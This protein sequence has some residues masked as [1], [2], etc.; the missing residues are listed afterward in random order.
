MF[1]CSMLHCSGYAHGAVQP[2]RCVGLVSCQ[3]LSALHHCS[4]GSL[5]FVVHMFVGAV[6]SR[7]PIQISQK[8]KAKKLKT[9]PFAFQLTFCSEL[10]QDSRSGCSLL[11]P[12]LSPSR[13]L[14][15][16]EGSHLHPHRAGRHPGARCR[17]SEQ[18]SPVPLLTAPGPC[19]R[20]E[21][22]A[23][24]YTGEPTELPS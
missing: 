17:L 23:G 13:P 12:S 21:T 1:A 6:S 22:P 19:C 20:S 10:S 8:T 24:S 14:S 5:N 18:T 4:G 16:N 2:H 11:H 9:A 15:H 3:M 7:L